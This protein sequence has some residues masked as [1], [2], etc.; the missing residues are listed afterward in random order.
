MRIVDRCQR[1][2]EQFIPKLLRNDNILGFV[3]YTLTVGSSSGEI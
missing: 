3:I 2:L 1:S